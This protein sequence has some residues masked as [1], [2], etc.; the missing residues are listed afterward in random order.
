PP[1]PPPG[2]PP[3]PGCEWLTPDVLYDIVAAERR[4][5]FREH[6]AF[7]DTFAAMGGRDKMDLWSHATPQIA[8]GDHTHLTEAGYSQAADLFLAQLL[9]GYDRWTA[10]RQP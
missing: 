10:R 8:Y 9:G 3:A 5:A 1:P 7:F 2:T 6:V 4:A